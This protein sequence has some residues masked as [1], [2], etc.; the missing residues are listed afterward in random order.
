M[1]NSQEDIITKNTGYLIFSYVV[2]KVL[3]FVFFV[4]LARF[5]SADELGKYVFAFSFTTIFAVAIDLGLSSVLTR[6]IAKDKTKIRAYLNNIIVFKLIASLVTYLAVVLSINLLGYPEL[7]KNLV[8]L[9]GL[10]MILDSFSLTFYAALRGIQ[11][12]K[13]E[14]LGTAY[15][16]ALIIFL[17]VT[18]L[19]LGLPLSIV[20]AVYVASSLFNAIYSF[21][22][23]KR[24]LAFHFEFAFDQKVFK[25]LFL[26]ALPFALAGIFNR[27]FSYIDTILLSKLAGDVAVGIYS[28]AYKLT[29]A[30]QF[31]P[32]ALGAALF[33]A[34]SSF[35]LRSSENLK[36]SFE[37]YFLYLALIALPIISGTIALAP[38]LIRALYGVRY[39]ESILPLQIL[40]MA[41][42]FIFFNYPIGSL[43]NSCDKQ[44]VNTII[45]GIAMAANIILNL[46]LIPKFSYAGSALAGLLSQGIWFILGLYQANKLIKIDKKMLGRKIALIFLSAVIMFFMIVMFKKVNWLLA[47]GF[48]TIFYFILIVVFRVIKIAEIKELIS[49]VIK[50]S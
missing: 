22:Q 5:L 9:T 39:L 31:I 23:A 10:V 49:T 2:Q 8:Y 48:S 32:A 19:F 1:A 13:F 36:K 30:L 21:W 29:Y 37:K 44:K 35:Y 24:N 14:A 47:G 11:N 34:M 20:V 4:I 41:L 7:T 40:I 43:L 45:V 38:E 16:Q 6:E 50:K 18:A 17:G 27:V 15:Y 12:L 25:I 26:I 42:A 3:A 28:I 33:P 46:L